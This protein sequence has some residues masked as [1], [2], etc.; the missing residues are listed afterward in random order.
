MA[1]FFD[2][3]FILQKVKVSSGIHL[4][5]REY[6]VSFIKLATK[7]MRLHKTQVDKTP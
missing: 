6:N 4:N 1:V 7:V 3:N 5:T 2:P